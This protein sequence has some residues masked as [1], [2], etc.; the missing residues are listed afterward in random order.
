MSYENHARIQVYVTLP[1]LYVN[2]Y[3]TEVRER[4]ST[5]LLI[6]RTCLLLQYMDITVRSDVEER[7]AEEHL[8]WNDKNI[9]AWPKN[10][11]VL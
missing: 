7:F 4:Q 6:V 1:L 2:L 10:F 11:S 9:P 5:K 8:A 3:R